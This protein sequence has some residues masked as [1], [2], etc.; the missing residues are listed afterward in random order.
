MRLTRQEHEEIVRQIVTYHIS[1]AN[2][3]SKIAVCHFVKQEI[4]RQTIYDV[5]KRYD[6]RKTT[7]FLLKS[8]RPS[9]LSNKDVQAPMKSVHSQTGISQP[10]DL[11]YDLVFINRRFHVLSKIKLQSN[12][13]SK[14]SP[15]IQ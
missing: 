4:S 2:S 10:R 6:E 11:H 3:V 14:I 8:D 13:Y 15:E 1:C 9:K 12:I 7:N 5:L